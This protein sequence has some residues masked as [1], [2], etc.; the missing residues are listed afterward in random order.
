TLS[1]APHRYQRRTSERARAIEYWP[2]TTPPTRVGPPICE[3]T[4]YVRPRVATSG[5][6]SHRPWPSGSACARRGQSGPPAGPAPSSEPDPHTTRDWDRRRSRRWPGNYE[7]LASRGCPSVWLKTTFTK[8]YSPCSEGY[9]RAPTRS[10]ELFPWWIQ[11]E[12]SARGWPAKARN[13]PSTSHRVQS[14]EPVTQPPENLC[15]TG[16]QP[17]GFQGG[18]GKQQPRKW[19]PRRRCEHRL[20]S[21]QL[22]P[23]GRSPLGRAIRRCRQHGH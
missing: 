8:P 12:P 11:V 6:R 17:G 5:A 7:K 2:G 13:T 18:D 22:P 16:Q 10:M 19:Y 1:F 14:V 4:R 23:P 15:G 21:H 20:R 3:F 9:S